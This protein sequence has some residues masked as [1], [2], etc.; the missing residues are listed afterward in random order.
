ME[1]NLQ[2]ITQAEFDA[3]LQ[4]TANPKHRLQLILMHDAGLRVT[5][6]CRV[7]WELCD[8]RTR[9]LTVESLKVR[10]PKPGSKPTK[11][12]TRVIPMS[13]RLYQAF[14]SYAEKSGK[15]EGYCFP[16][17]D[18]QAPG[19]SSV[20][21]LLKR[22]EAKTPEVEG[23]HPH[24]LRHSF[25]TDLRAQGADLTDLADLLGHG[26]TKTTRIYAHQ[27]NAK[28]RAMMDAPLVR[29]SRSPLAWF[30]KIFSS[31]QTRPLSIVVPDPK[32]LVGRHS[33]VRA[34]ETAIRK[35][36]SVIL[37]GSIGVGKTH[38][39]DNLQYN[40]PVLQIDSC[41]GFKKS[42]VSGILHMSETK[43]TA[44]E[45]LYGS[46][47]PGA[48]NVKLSKESLI[49]LCSTLCSIC[50]KK[51]Y[52]LQIGHVDDITPSVVRALEKL[53]EHFV[54]VTTAR[55]IAPLLSSWIWDFDR[56][57]VNP[58]SR[59]DSLR[60]FIRL[61]SELQISS[62]E[63]VKN[64]VHETAEGNPRVVIELAE[65]FGKELSITPEIVDEI[66][67]N[68]IGRQVKEIDMSLML[69]LC[70]G[71]FA[72]LRY[73]GKETNDSSLQMIGGCIMIVLLFA[74]YFFNSTKRISL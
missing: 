74:R 8:F 37:T 70:L 7:R 40:K 38:I 53:R 67:A 1:E 69:L 65:R 59:E 61:T 68:Y 54:I 11:P 49:N 55:K 50:E 45:M 24:K 43:A 71:G 72:V 14:V 63:Y 32:I 62:P 51:E 42:I 25:A 26:D 9:K 57:Q 47:E 12:K 5:E 23:L 18:G 46:A 27:D 6:C 66:T 10:K 19:R 16:G 13:A 36:I 56:I 41:A 48:L 44:M 21:M 15:S 17:K 30:T 64:K 58:L 52:I 34:I 33:E 28:I 39:I 20:N 4:S 22:L 60:I 35:D 31:R 2:I 73:V 3:V 29:A